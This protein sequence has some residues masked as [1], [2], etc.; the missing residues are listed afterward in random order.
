MP[1]FAAFQANLN[2]HPA[3]EYIPERWLPAAVGRTSPFYDDNCDAQPHIVG[4]RTVYAAYS[5]MRLILAR[6]L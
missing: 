4:P 5:D 3:D 2:L 1:Q 6:V